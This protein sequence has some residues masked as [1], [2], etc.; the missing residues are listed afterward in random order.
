MSKDLVPQ[1]KTLF[2]Q[3]GDAVG[4]VGGIDRLSCLTEKFLLK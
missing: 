4:Q 1:F 3:H 2:G